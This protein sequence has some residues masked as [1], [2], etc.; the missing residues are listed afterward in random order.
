[1]LNRAYLDNMHTE[2]IYIYIYWLVVWNSRDARAPPSGAA[3]TYQSSSFFVPHLLPWH[4]V[5]SPR[6]LEMWIK[7]S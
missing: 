6:S 4:V 1:M 5:H 2:Y 7:V 3:G